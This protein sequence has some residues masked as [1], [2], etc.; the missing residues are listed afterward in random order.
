MCH[1]LCL[2]LT[3]LPAL[4][5]HYPEQ[6]AVSLFAST[7]HPVDMY[8]I[9]EPKNG[10]VAIRF[11][12]QAQID[13]A[14]P[15]PPELKTNPEAPLRF[16]VRAWNERQEHLS[17]P[18]ILGGVPFWCQQ[19]QHQGNFIAQLGEACGISGDGLVYL[20]DDTVFAQFT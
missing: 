16:R 10:L 4:Q 18:R 2:D 9:A 13:A 14:P 20:F 15:A 11:S 6:R 7:A 8:E 3:A 19:Q 12:T 5:A 17:R 1:L